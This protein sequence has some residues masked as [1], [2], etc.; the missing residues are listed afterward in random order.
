MR[1][2]RG[3]W[4]AAAAFAAVLA[5]SSAWGQGSPIL[6]ETRP[7]LFG[8]VTLYPTIALREVGSDS[9]VFNDTT[10]PKGDFTYSVTPR[11]FVVAPVANTR[12]IGRALG[13]FTDFQTYKD[14]RSLGGLFDIRYEFVSPGFRP[15]ASLGFADR[16]ERRGVEIDARV[17][18]R[19]T[20]ASLGLDVDLTAITALTV[21]ANRTTTGW[22]RNER[23]LG[24]GL[25]DQLDYSATTLTGGV[26][27]RVTPLTTLLAAAEVEQNRFDRSPV[28]DANSVRIGPR[29]DFESSAAITGHAQVEYR[30]FAPLS[31]DVASFRGMTAFADL[32][33]LFRDRVEVKIEAARDLDYSFD[34]VQPYFL[35]V[36]GRFTVTQR[37][38]GPFGLVAI[39]ERWDVHHQQIGGMSFDG[40]HDITRAAGAGFAIQK[41]KQLRFELV[42]E[43]TSRTSS[44]PGWRDYERQRVFASAIYGQ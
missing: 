23:Y 31:P 27:F 2:S 29:V 41:S 14:Q 12:F 9:N 38:V 18:Q 26:R 30:S 22:D 43:K 1:V 15:F 11:L 19:Q 34:P 13:N 7:I 21:W 3:G 6:P 25:A 8:P 17:R 24:V 5:N 35:E 28:R 32:R 44:E 37:V 42:Y 39:G 36:G 10:G 33:Y 16:R 40:R 20:F 4:L